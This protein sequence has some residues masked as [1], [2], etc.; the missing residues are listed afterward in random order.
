MPQTLRFS[1][2][3]YF[4]KKAD[5]DLKLWNKDS[6]KPMIKCMSVLLGAL[7][8]LKFWLDLAS[9]V[10]P[11]LSRFCQVGNRFVLLKKPK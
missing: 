9:G 5:L 7:G 6:I 11:V 4:G 8:Y 10:L 1:F 3:N 2:T